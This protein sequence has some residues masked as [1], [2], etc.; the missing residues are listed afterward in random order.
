MRD[1]LPSAYYYFFWLVEP[2]LTLAGAAYAIFLPTTYAAALLPSGVERSTAG[3]GSTVRGQMVVCCLGSCFLLLALISFSLFPTVRALP[4]AHQEPVVRAL[5][6]PLAVA[7]L[8]H[9]ALTLLPLPLSL[10]LRPGQ[11]TGPIYG[12]VA[13]TACLFLA[14]A[15]Y[16]AGLG[17]GPSQARALT[18]STRTASTASASASAGA[19]PRRSVRG[20]KSAAQ[21]EVERAVYG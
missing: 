15:A 16:L 2:I 10:V 12:N 8:V 13:I 1:P 9:I 21:A 3:L 14:R 19:T 18:P 6:V 7:D 20:R 11:W 5:L 17:R 4:A